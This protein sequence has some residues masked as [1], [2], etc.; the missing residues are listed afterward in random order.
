MI[1]VAAGLALK[2]KKFKFTLW[3]HLLSLRCLEQENVVRVVVGFIS[4]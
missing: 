1:N 2:N 4:N 3:L